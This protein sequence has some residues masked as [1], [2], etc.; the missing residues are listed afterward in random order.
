MEQRVALTN[1][2]GLHAR[3]I[4]RVVEIAGRHAAVLEV[5][6]DGRCADG[7]SVFDLMSLGAG[8]GAELL[9]RAEGDDARALIQELVR[10][11]EEK[12]GES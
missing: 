9:L 11:V 3:P 4:S 12:F 1:Q 7:R 8:P 6:F 2:S 5:C 10:L